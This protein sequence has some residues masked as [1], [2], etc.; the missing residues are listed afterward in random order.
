[1]CGLENSW[2]PVIHACRVFRALVFVTLRGVTELNVDQLPWDCG[3]QR[4][5]QLFVRVLHG[6]FERQALRIDTINP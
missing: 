2:A 4:R 6:V 5:F 3:I 1:M